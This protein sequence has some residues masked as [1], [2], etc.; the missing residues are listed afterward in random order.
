MEAQRDDCTVLVY[1]LNFNA[2]EKEVFNFFARAGIGRV[3]DIKIIRDARSGKSKGVSYVEFES[4]ESVLLAVALS[5]Q[6]IK[7]NFL[8]GF[9]LMK[10]P[11]Q[12]KKIS[13]IFRFFIFDIKIFDI[14][15]CYFSFKANSFYL[16]FRKYQQNLDI[17]LG[18]LNFV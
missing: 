2:T 10:I 14:K 17:F 16:D 8:L 7:S 18:Y 15:I 9:L 12:I 11:N 1:R 3:I 13:E 6:P 4:Q 5:G